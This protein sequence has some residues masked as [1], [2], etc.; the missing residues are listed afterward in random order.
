[1]Q[2]IIRRAKAIGLCSKF[3]NKER[4]PE[5]HSI[6]KKIIAL[7]LLPAHQIEEGLEHVEKLAYEL[8]ERQDRMADE[9]AE[10]TGKKRR[11]A[12]FLI[13]WKRLFK[14]FQG[15]WIKKVKPL[16][17]SLFDCPIRTNNL[18]ERWHRYLNDNLGGKPGVQKFISKYCERKNYLLIFFI[19]V[20][21]LS[22]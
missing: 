17:L 3:N 1:M 14:Y 11:S 5:S 13:M 2:A 4:N 8:G 22:N 7:A 18:L 6:L 10:K 12:S 9:E 16:F 19:L 20:L 15:E 21:L